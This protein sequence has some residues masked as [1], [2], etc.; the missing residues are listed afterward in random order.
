[1]GVMVFSSCPNCKRKNTTVRSTDHDE[2][3]VW[4]EL[5]LCKKCL[6]LF[7]V[8]LETEVITEEIDKDESE[9]TNEEG[10]RE[11]Y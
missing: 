7:T 11:F 2:G 5:I 8:K 1:V 10:V 6:N 4:Y 3:G 9:L